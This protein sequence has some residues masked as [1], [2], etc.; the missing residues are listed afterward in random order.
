MDKPKGIK[1]Q[2]SHYLILLL[3][4]YQ[5]SFL[6]FLLEERQIYFY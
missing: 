4:F 2:I 1:F 5:E 6:F 3:A